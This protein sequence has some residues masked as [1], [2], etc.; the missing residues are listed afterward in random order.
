[1]QLSVSA[2]LGVAMTTKDA[3]HITVVL[4]FF[5]AQLLVF[6]LAA[7][8]VRGLVNDAWIFPLIAALLLMLVAYLRIYWVYIRV[9]VP[10]GMAGV[11]RSPQQALQAIPGP[12][13]LLQMPPF[14]RV[15]VF[16][17]EQK[18]LD[19]THSCFT[20][21]RI[22]VNVTV[23]IFYRI[24]LD[25]VVAHLNKWI[26]VEGEIKRYLCAKLSLDMA[27]CELVN[28]ASFA[29]RSV[30][31]M[32]AAMNQASFTQNGAAIRQI[33]VIDI[34]YPIDIMRSA[35]EL[36]RARNELEVTKA[37]AAARLLELT[38]EID[39]RVD[40]LHKLEAAIKTVSKATLDYV[41]SHT[42]LDHLDKIPKK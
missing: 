23:S 39:S 35:E 40:E 26:D 33:M 34:K 6:W 13:V 28:L 11:I 10:A 20:R 3:N 17:L 1:M 4:L 16:S 21:D 14:R 12:I 30:S 37:R 22:K 36:V 2:L 19:L 38:P 29:P 41:E 31:L 42:V 5:I 18:P 27:S 25:S 24:P 8:V 9:E 7:S 32:A 15:E